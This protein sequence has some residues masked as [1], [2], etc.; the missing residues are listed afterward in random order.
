MGYQRDIMK[1][2][3]KLAQILVDINPEVYG[4][5]ITYENGKAE[6]YLEFLKS[7]YGILIVSLLFYQNLRKHLESIGFRVNPYDPCV[8]NKMICDKQIKTTWHVDDLK[9]SHSDTDIVETF[10]QCT[11]ET[12]EG[13]TRL[14]TSIGNVHDYQSMTL[15]YTTSG[16]VQIYMKECIDKLI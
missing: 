16:E 9:V 15:D 1:I 6:V 4:L 12:Y 7:L 3:G 5:Y 14:N 10:I 11:K 13:V 2:R 8:A